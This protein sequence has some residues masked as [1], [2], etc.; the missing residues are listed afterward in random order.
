TR[1]RGGHVLVDRAGGGALGIELWIVLVGLDQGLVHGAR[2]R[3]GAHQASVGGRLGRERSDPEGRRRG[4]G[5]RRN[6]RAPGYC[7][8]PPSPPQ[9]AQPPPLPCRRSRSCPPLTANGQCEP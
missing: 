9:H 5:K 2:A 6:A 4:Y 1:E 3:S 7:P 8:P